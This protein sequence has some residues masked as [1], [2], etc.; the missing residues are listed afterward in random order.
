M[1]IDTDRPRKRISIAFFFYIFS[2]WI[3]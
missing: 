3:M 2:R 1:Q